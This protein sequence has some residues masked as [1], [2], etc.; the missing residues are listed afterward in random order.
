MK[1]PLE[2]MAEKI[3]ELE[4]ALDLGDVSSSG[5]KS[6]SSFRKVQDKHLEGSELL[7]VRGERQMHYAWSVLFSPQ[8]LL[9]HSWSQVS[10][11]Y[12][13]LKEAL[14]ELGYDVEKT[15][16]ELRDKWERVHS[17]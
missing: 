3:K 17:G 7:R 8:Y 13:R 15:K 5:K 4:P 14:S 11:E 9:S 12:D 10:R 2:E 1:D 16:R 6:R